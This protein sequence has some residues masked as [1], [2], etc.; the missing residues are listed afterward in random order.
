MV[1]SKWKVTFAM[2]AF[3]MAIPSLARAQS[4]ITGLVRDASGAVLP[5]VTVEA[6]SPALI[7]KTRAVTTDGE[8]R[9]TIVDLRPGVYTVTFSL[10]SRTRAPNELGKQPSTARRYPVFIPSSINLPIR[11]ISSCVGGAPRSTVL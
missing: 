4:A 5:G 11:A 10:E 2:L 8:G 6:A 9:Y 3:L 7:E 1:S